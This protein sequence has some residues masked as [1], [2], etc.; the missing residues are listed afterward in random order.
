MQQEKVLI[1]TL[2][3]IASVPGLPRFDLLFALTI[4][5]GS[6]R[7]M[8][9][10]LAFCSRVLLWTQT[11]GKHGR[12]LRTRLLSHTL[13]QDWVSLVTFIIKVGGAK[14]HNSFYSWESI[15]IGTV[16]IFR[17]LWFTEVQ[18]AKSLRTAETSDFFSLAVHIH[19]FYAFIQLTFLPFDWST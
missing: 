10:S 15:S 4:I 11:E 19:L 1:R 9:I 8:K 17:L 6:R 2:F 14:Y 3:L 18:L 7:S 12:G 5:H 16:Y 13:K